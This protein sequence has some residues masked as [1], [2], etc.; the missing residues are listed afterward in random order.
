MRK[1]KV[2]HQTANNYVLTL[3]D[4]TELLFGIDED[5]PRFCGYITSIS[6]ASEIA[7][8]RSKITGAD[9]ALIGNSFLDGR[10]VVLNVS[11]ISPDPI[12]RSAQI[13]RLYRLYEGL[14]ADL[15]LEWR[16]ATGIY[17]AVRGLRVANYPA[18]EHSTGIAKNIQ[19][20]LFSPE[21]F[22]QSADLHQAENLAPGTYSLYNLGNAPAY[23]TFTVS[24]PLGSFQ[25]T[26]DDTGQAIALYP[27]AALL[28][29]ESISI[30]C[31]P[32]RRSVKKGA[33]NYYA[34]LSFDSS[35]FLAIEAGG[36]DI[37]FS[38]VGATTDTRLRVDWRSSWV[39]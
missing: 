16:E 30:D 18:L 23:P 33:A 5:D 28:N 34:F 17:K 35:D 13:E 11:I 14:Q 21:P 31:S 25:I 12:E 32:L 39:G 19:I 29:T 26:N 27:N 38:A 7:L 1:I 24:G 9:G 22:I 15:T 6:S 10:S 4:G 36:N 8:N 37:T 2:M 3:P 20:S